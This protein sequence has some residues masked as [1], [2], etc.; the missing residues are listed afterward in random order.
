MKRKRKLKIMSLFLVFLMGFNTVSA[1]LPVLSIAEDVSKILHYDFK[2]VDG[3]TVF[4][5]VNSYHGEIVNISQAEVVQDHG[6]G[7][8]S[9]PGGQTDSY[10]TIPEGVL[11]DVTDVTISTLVNWGGNNAAEWLFALGQN[12]HRYLYFTPRYNTDNS[13]RFGIASDAWRN[14]TTA[15]TATFSQNDWKLVTTVLSESDETLKLYIDG[16]LVGSGPTNGLTVADIKNQGGAS[17]YI[18]RSFYNNDPHFG[19]K[20]ADFQIHNRALS[21]GEILELKEEA[22]LRVQYIEGEVVLPEPPAFTNADIILHYDMK[23]TAEENGQVV[24]KDVSGSNVTFDGIF[25]NPH[26]GQ[27]VKNNDVGYVGFNG[28]SSNSGYIEIPKGSN[29]EDLLH[30]LEDVTVS[31]LVNWENDGQNRW[32]FGLGRVDSDIE[33][34]NSYLFVTPRHGID[35]SNVVAT[36]ISEGGWRGETLL[37]GSSSLQARTW[38]V[39]TLVFKDSSNTMSLYVN[40]EQVVTGSAGNKKIENIIDSSASFSGFIGKSIFGN[41]PY[42]QGMVADFRVFNGA[43]TEEEVGEVYNNTVTKVDK[44]GELV[45]NDARDSLNVA[46]YLSESDESIDKITRNIVLPSTGKHG[47]VVSWR[48][49]NPD[50]ITNDGKVTRP[51]ADANDEVVDLTA[52]LSYEGLTV[53]RVFSV[54]VLKEFSDEQRVTLDAERLVIYNQDQIKGNL[55]L[56][57]VGEEGSSITWESSKPEIIKGT[58]QAGVDIQQLGWVTRPA[59]DTE[60]TLT[61]TVSYGTDEVVRT[62]DVTVLEDPGELE[63][64]AYFFSYFTGE[65]EGGEEISFATAENPLMWRALNNGESVIQSHMGEEGLRDPFIIRSPEGD[66]FYMLATDLKMGESHNFDQAQITGSHYLMIWESDDLVNWSEQRM[67]KVAPENGGNTWAPEAFYDKNTGD[68]VVF[69]ASSMKN[70]DTYGHYP[71]GRPAGQYNVMYYATTRDFH[72]FSEPKVFIDEGFPTI[73]TTFIEHDDTLYRFTKSEVNM[74][75][76]YEKAPHIFYDADGIEENGF[77][78]ETI[79]GTRDGNRGLIGHQ[80]NNEGQ[81]VFKDLHEDKWYL[82]LDSWPYHVRYTTDLEDGQQFV[83]NLLPSSEFALPP[84]PRHGTVIPIT[85]DEYDAIHDR[86]AVPGPEQSEGP[87]VRYTFNPEHMD[88]TTVKDVSGN[89]FDAILKG[90]AEIVTEDI[91]GSSA[92]AVDLD[93]STGYV[94]LPENLIQDLNLESMTMST[95][96]KVKGNQTN[97]R[98]F[99]FSSETGRLVNRNTMYLSTQGDSGILEFAIVTPFTEKFANENTLLGSNYKYALRAPRIST[100]QWQHVAITIDGFDAVMYVNGAEVSRSSVYNMEPR[101]L[102]ETTMNFLGKSRRD[103]HNLFNGMF[104]DFQIYNRALSSEEIIELANEDYTPPIDEPTGKELILHYDMNNVDGSTVVDATGNFDGTWMNPQNAQWINGDNVGAIS[105]EGGTTS[106]YIRMPQGVLDGLESVTVS[107]LVNWK[108]N[109]AAEWIFALGQDNNKYLFTTP[110]RNSGNGS[111]RLGLGITSWQNEAGVNASIGSLDS[112]D[113]KLVTAVMNGQEETLSLYIDGVEVG[114]DSTR[115]YTLE[116]INNTNGRSGFI[117][118][119]FYSADPFFGGMVADFQVYNDALSASDVQGLYEDITVKISELDGFMLEHVANQVDYSDFINGNDSKDEITRDLSF[120]AT[121]PF[122]TTFIWESTNE[123]LITNE[124]KVTRPSYEEGN[125]EVV[126]TLTITDGVG[127][128]TKD[129]TVTVLRRPTDAEAIINDA[130]TLVVHNINDVRGNLTLKTSGEKGSSITWKSEDD[131][132]ITPTGE[133]TRPAHGSGDTTVK[134]MAFITLNNETISKA[135]IANVKELPEDAEYEAYF[136]SY[137]RGEGRADGEQIYFALSNGNDP[138]NYTAL[139][140][141]QPLIVSQLGEQGLRDAFIIRS[142]EG[143]KFYMIATDLKIH[144]NGDWHRAQTN[145]SRS[146]MVWESNDLV[147]W[148]EQRMVE[149]AP[150]E[151]GNTWAPEIFYDHTTGEYVVFWASKLYENEAQ[152]NSGATHHRMVATKTRDF[153]TFTDPEVYIDYGYS[154]ID[155][156]MIEHDGKIYRFS[157]DERNNSSSAPNGKYIFQEVGDSIFGDFELIKEGVGRPHVGHTEGPVVFKSN[158]EEKWYLFVDEF[159]QRGYVP[160]ETTDLDSGEW[161]V[162]ANY[163]FPAGYRHGSVVPITGEEYTN[164]QANLPRVEEP[165]SDIHASE[166]ILDLESVD[167]LVGEEVKLTATVT[168]EDAVNKEVVWSTSNEDVAEVDQDGK[169]IAL[170][171][172]K[173]YITVAT[174]DGGLMAVSVVSVQEDSPP[175]DGGET[176]PPGDG[177]ETPPPGDGGET[178]PPGD[179]GETPPPGDGGDTPPPGDGGDTP[180][181]GDGDDT[182]P[183]GDG[184]ETPP[185]GDGGDTPSPGDGGDTSPPGDGGD[186]SPPG[187]KDNDKAKD[188]DMELPLTATNLSLFLLIGVVLLVGGLVTYFGRKRIRCITINN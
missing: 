115:G 62:F 138:L 163:S 71:N 25:R 152:R 80:G 17:G 125:Q 106:S 26:N 114:T 73:D 132:I 151:A 134:L 93:G 128:V 181:P 144:G 35:N 137:M 159:A 15:R 54:I 16:E 184:G 153:Y 123:S 108:G 149:V 99:D 76:Y 77:Q 19:G 150:P 50:V 86:Y 130:R 143:D 67:A 180:P 64:D 187:D 165:S 44:I 183:P 47:V 174:V 186:T 6:Y 83:N 48:S 60:V 169:V 23:T 103:S 110:R 135:F 39:V 12:D 68:Y 157:K 29:G 70:E 160:L 11:N 82:F 51:S 167:L 79:P 10:I 3:A 109:N 131:S 63:Y 178:P 24:V 121:G 116:E 185:P 37:R 42:F 69:W 65:Y 122:N 148:S 36:G 172:G 155:T 164:L 32:I 59:V 142:P 58:E 49:S 2:N 52:T 46:D 98:I 141:N 18:G 81:T 7:Y 147:N 161:T 89:G 28:G 146:I 101:M 129:F 112:G 61:A 56:L 14:E 31:A 97:Q 74:R 170:A 75:V 34:G 43:L 30:D 127:T 8:V 136:S 13:A 168:P 156:T 21:E 105:F 154:V 9:F 27:L 90:G 84:G 96:V 33:Y 158:T 145:G 166:V 117:G 162:P 120:S 57:T 4:D 95:W 40:G 140:N 22:D 173:V 126:I 171:T 119:S 175:G 104:D 124:G 72:T 107:S 100:S 92:G 5:T 85:R 53:E 38:E 182:S 139:N 113:W 176:P 188:K 45:I 1:A 66:K 179:G 78:F 177:G 91:I 102:L 20:V 133:V 41:D 55:R 111:A 88:G 94:E 87:V 118:R